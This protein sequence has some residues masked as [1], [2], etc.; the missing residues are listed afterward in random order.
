MKSKKEIKENGKL[1][2]I[3]KVSPAIDKYKGMPVCKGCKKM[4]MLEK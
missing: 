1:C 4:I 2:G 3:C